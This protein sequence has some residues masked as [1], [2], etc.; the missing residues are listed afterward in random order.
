MRKRGGRALPTL[1]LVGDAAHLGLAVADLAEVEA[2]SASAER[3][4]LG[5][6]SVL[7]EGGAE[8]ATSASRL[9]HA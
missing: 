4:G 7:V 6:A 2:D 3:V 1:L 5:V 8:A 9:P